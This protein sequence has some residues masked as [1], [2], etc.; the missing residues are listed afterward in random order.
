MASD[1]V[2]SGVDDSDPELAVLLEAARRATWDALEGPPHLRS[3]RFDPWTDLARPAEGSAYGR[4]GT[5]AVLQDALTHLALPAEQQR[6]VL[7][8]LGSAPSCDE[9]GL[10]L[11]DAMQTPGAQRAGEARPELQPLLVALGHALTALPKDAWHVDALDGEEW[12][13]IRSLAA[14]ALALLVLP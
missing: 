10:Q 3:G 1:S 12:S 8:A 11:D 13:R 4:N 6:F 5:P 7:R 14:R 9:L 2:T